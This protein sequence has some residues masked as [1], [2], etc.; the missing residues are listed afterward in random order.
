MFMIDRAAW[1]TAREQPLRVHKRA[2]VRALGGGREVP[3]D[4]LQR[5]SDA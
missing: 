5:G 1:P 4:G 2:A 3:A